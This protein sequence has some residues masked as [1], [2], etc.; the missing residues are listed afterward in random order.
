VGLDTDNGGEF[1]N[2]ELL[3]YCKEEKITFTRSRAYRKNDQAHVE[4]KNG[5]VVRRLVG[6]DRYEGIGAWRA[7]RA[8]YG[9]LRLYVNFFQPSMK[10]LSK[11]RMG[12]RTKKRYDSARTPYQRVLDSELVTEDGK[13]QLRSSYQNLDPVALLKELEKLQDCFWEYAHKKENETIADASVRKECSPVSLTQSDA[14]FAKSSEAS[15][16]RENTPRI[17]RR[18]KKPIVQRTWRTRP[19]PFVDVWGQ[20]QVQLR[21]D[22]TC[23]AKKLFLEL[24]ARY[25]GKFQDGQLRT[26][27]RRVQGWRRNYQYAVDAIHYPTAETLSASVQL[28]V[29]TDQSLESK[30]TLGVHCGEGGF[31]R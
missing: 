28:P 26:L 8:L 20:I 9:V 10:L 23:N 22:P 5:S 19:D 11:E 14:I 12:G 30:T 31:G 13:T 4:E 27:Q 17:Y 1:I 16:A 25:P 29:T 24:Q 7:L 18:A 2:Y 15:M 6:Y 3:R 21:I